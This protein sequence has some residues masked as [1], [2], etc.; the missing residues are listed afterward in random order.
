MDLCNIEKAA[1][2]L[3]KVKSNEVNEHKNFYLENQITFLRTKN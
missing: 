3:Q 2:E 1:M